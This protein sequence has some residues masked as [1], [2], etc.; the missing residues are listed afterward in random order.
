MGQLTGILTAGIQLG[1]ESVLVKPA[2]RLGQFVAQVTIQE[3]H[4]DE[5]EI[6]D[7]PVESGAIISDHA[8]MRPAEVVLEL[9]W[10]DSPSIPGGLGGLAQGLLGAV[11]TT[12][13]GVGALITGNTPNQSRDVYQK[14]LDL[15]KS[16]TLFDIFTGKRAYSN[17]LIKSLRV[18][19]NKE[20]ENSLMATI[21][22][23][24][25]IIV[26]T[27]IV[28]V[29]APVED[30]ADPSQTAPTQNKGTKSLNPAPNYDAGAGRGSINPELP[31]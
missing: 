6:T 13:S 21:V 12:V 15:Q 5:L 8:F 7:H 18:V 19:T 23:R 14:L 29:A 26:T 3:S 16:R 27:R 20:S 30:Q 4:T 31:T 2:R 9:A 11:T 28:S 1:V 22:C 24:Q 10:S 25:L 17:M